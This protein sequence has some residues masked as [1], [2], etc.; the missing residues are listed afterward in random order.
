MRLILIIKDPVL[1][2]W[3]LEVLEKVIGKRRQDKIK[4]SNR[5]MNRNKKYLKIKTKMIILKKD[6]WGF[7]KKGNPYSLLFAKAYKD[8]T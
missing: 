2:L 5:K 1:R 8:L 7:N 3:I 4:F 6:N